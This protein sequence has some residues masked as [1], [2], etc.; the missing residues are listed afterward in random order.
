[1]FTIPP[2]SQIFPYVGLLA[3][4]AQSP[5]QEYDNIICKHALNLFNG[6]EPVARHWLRAETTFRRWA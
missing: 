2:S 4:L 6:N 3:R 5:D 1:M